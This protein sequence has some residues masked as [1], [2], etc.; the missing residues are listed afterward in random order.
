M[1]ALRVTGILPVFNGERYVG[2][3]L[4]SMLAQ[5]RPLHEII[6]VDDGSRDGTADVVASYGSRVRLVR[7]ENAGPGVARNT[8]VRHADGD[9]V[10][11]LDADDLW[12]EEKVARQLARFE[13]RNE[14]EICVTLI[15]NFWVSELDAERERLKDHPRGKPVP[16][17]IS[18]T[19]MARRAVFVKVGDFDSSL[20]YGHAA[21]WFVRARACDVVE[22]LLPEVLTFRRLHPENRSRQHADRSLDE[23]LRFLKSAAD[24]RRSS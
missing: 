19:L 7:Q 14:L 1:T 21:D 20:S 3:A 8:G 4:D 12:H 15:Q 6:V 5:T 17:Y 11:F 2:E 9:L 18:Q 10:A 16:G 24:K 22:E 13:A 23:F